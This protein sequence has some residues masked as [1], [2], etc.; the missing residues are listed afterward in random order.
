MDDARHGSAADDADNADEDAGDGAPFP[1]PLPPVAVALA[2][3]WQQVPLALALRETHRL[4]ALGEV[5]GDRP[6]SRRILDVGVGDG[7]WWRHLL[8]GRRDVYG[9]D[10]SERELGRA[11]H[12]LPHVACIDVSAPDFGGQLAREGLPAR[13]GGI[14]AN[15]SL[16]HVPNL[17]GALQ[18]LYA[19]LEP[20][21]W[22]VLFVPTPWWAMQ[23]FT[24][25]LLSTHAHR[26]AMMASGA[27][28]GFF[29]HWHLMDRATWKRLLSSY[30]FVVERTVALGD[31]RSET[32]FRLML[33]PSLLGFSVKQLTGRYAN[34][35]APAPVVRALAARIAGVIETAHSDVDDADAYEFAIRVTK[36]R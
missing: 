21:G 33:P 19:S 35:L 23:G 32:L 8:A 29:Q 20:G 16:E 18:N 2:S 28:N 17:D 13:Y 5:L 7:S 3:A 15:C 27:M 26:L 31:A 4:I 30:G 1:P 36:P 10:V 22:F 34:P 14:I 25:S 24:Q 12:A 9:V 6:A 11:R